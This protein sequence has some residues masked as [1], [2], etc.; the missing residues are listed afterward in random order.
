MGG[1]SKGKNKSELRENV[2]NVAEEG[3][4]MYLLDYHL[5]HRSWA[6]LVQRQLTLSGNGRRRFNTVIG[7]KWA[8]R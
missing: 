5:L 6:P 2:P 7:W 4:F 1:I 8:K 3:S